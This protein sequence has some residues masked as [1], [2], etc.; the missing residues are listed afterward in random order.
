MTGKRNKTRD[1]PLAD[2][3]IE[4]LRAHAEGFTASEEEGGW[5]EGDRPLIFA[6]AGSVPQWGLVDGRVRLVSVAEEAGGALSGAG[7][8]ALLKRFFGRAAASGGGRGAGSRAV[9][10]GV[11]A[12][13]APHF[14]A[15]I[16]RG[17][18]AA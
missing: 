16:A 6:L 10:S 1:V 13:D 18:G 15:A 14:C 7:I 3:V 2:E 4:L 17:R 8:Y 9:R 5:T 12:L 11:D